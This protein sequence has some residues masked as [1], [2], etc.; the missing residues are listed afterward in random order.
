MGCVER[1]TGK[2]GRVVGVYYLA[3]GTAL[4]GLELNAAMVRAGWALAYRGYSDD[5]D[6]VEA[7]AHARGAGIWGLVFVPPWIWRAG[8]N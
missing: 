3:G 6:V 2:F 7:V 1:G 8:T 4:G 5:Y